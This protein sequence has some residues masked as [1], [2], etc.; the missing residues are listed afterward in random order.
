MNLSVS[1]NDIDLKTVIELVLPSS[2][3]VL[4]EGQQ[5][6][7][8]GLP[9]NGMIYLIQTDYKKDYDK[10]VRDLPINVM[11]T[12]LA[13]NEMSTLPRLFGLF[14][15]MDRT[16]TKIFNSKD[17]FILHMKLHFSNTEKK[18]SKMFYFNLLSYILIY[19][20]INLC[21]L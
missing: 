20:L 8:K 13:F 9:I 17:L 16:C 5:I 2:E 4:E 21:V 19:F 6:V 18:K 1:D 7:N 14:K 11:K 10:K 12:K 15:C 3:I